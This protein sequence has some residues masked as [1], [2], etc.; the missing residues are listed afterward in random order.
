MVV[1]SL[2]LLALLGIFAQASQEPREHLPTSVSNYNNW[3]AHSFTKD[4]RIQEFTVNATTAMTLKLIEAYGGCSVLVTD[5]ETERLNDLNMGLVSLILYPGL[6]KIAITVD[7]DERDSDLAIILTR[8]ESAQGKSMLSA[9]VRD[10]RKKSL[11]GGPAGIQKPHFEKPIRPMPPNANRRRRGRKP[12]K[13]THP[14][15]ISYE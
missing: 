7:V 11:P 12:K 9:K 14:A 2:L 13:P 4:T 5:N 10:G 1:A 6:H 3:L 15:A 8:V